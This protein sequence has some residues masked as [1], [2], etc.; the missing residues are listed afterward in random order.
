M[1]EGEH[2]PPQP[3]RREE[4]KLHEKLSEREISL[5]K[6]LM[7]IVDNTVA[8]RRMSALSQASAYKREHP[9]GGEDLVFAE[10]V[11]K[12]CG[13]FDR[14]FQE[15]VC[16]HLGLSTTEYFTLYDEYLRSTRAE[17]RASDDRESKA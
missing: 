9:E 11:L 13:E 16:K 6:D 17:R 10:T 2:A 3:E 14:R 1:R 4:A 15:A 8:G 12:Q 7:R 5:T